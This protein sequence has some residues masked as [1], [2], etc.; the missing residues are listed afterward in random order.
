MELDRGA[1]KEKKPA[2]SDRGQAFA[3]VTCTFEEVKY[4]AICACAAPPQL[5]CIVVT[6]K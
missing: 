2:R 4:F 5:F 6:A 3:S 1:L